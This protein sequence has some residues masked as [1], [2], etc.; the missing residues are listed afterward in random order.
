MKDNSKDK[1]TTSFSRPLS[2]KE[3]LDL[4]QLKM[5]EKE[6]N[7]LIAEMEQNL[8]DKQIETEDEKR[9]REILRSVGRE[10][11]EDFLDYLKNVHFFTA[12]ASVNNHGNRKGGLV[13]HSL[14]VYD[15]AMKFREEMI[16]ED[17]SVAEYLSNENIAVAA[18][19]HDIC[20][21]DELK[22]KADGTPAH[23]LSSAN[24]GGHGYKSVVLIMLHDYKLI[25]D[26]VLAIRWHMGSKDIS[27][28]RDMD[29]YKRAKNDA[30][31]RLIVRAD[32]EATTS[33]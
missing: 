2:P 20:L 21:A 9:F 26:E 27:D 11:T 19:L 3:F 6:K 16:R 12:P 29:E 28:P 14:K 33:E 10:N 15:Y 23:Q 1:T 13:N 4:F 7:E 25:G 17:P 30:L 31:V 18:L 32:N 5:G 8:V 24:L 22:V